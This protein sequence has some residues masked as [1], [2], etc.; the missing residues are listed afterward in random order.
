M[1]YSYPALL[2]CPPFHSQKLNSFHTSPAIPDYL[3]KKG[4]E[5]GTTARGRHVRTV[6]SEVLEQLRAGS[7]SS[8]KR[9]S[10]EL[11]RTV[12]IYLRITR[13]NVY[14]PAFQSEFSKRSKSAL[15]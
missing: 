13:D 12:E 4:F 3:A 6:A 15:G 10:Q 1:D 7:F 9:R 5:V 2:E 11:S 14:M 8:G